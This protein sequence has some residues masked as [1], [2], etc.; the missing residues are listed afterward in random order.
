VTVDADLFREV[1]DRLSAN[2]LQLAELEAVCHEHRTRAWFEVESKLVSERDRV[3]DYQTL[4]L[5]AD[6]IRLKGEIRSDEDWVAYYTVVLAR[7][8]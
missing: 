2:R 7:P 4:D 6:I 1:T 8:G 3:A 5:T